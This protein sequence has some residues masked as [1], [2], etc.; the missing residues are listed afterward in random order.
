MILLAIHVAP[1]AR[2]APA[3]VS[4]SSA[5]GARFPAIAQIAGDQLT[6]ADDTLRRLRG[7]IDPYR[8]TPI[9]ASYRLANLIQQ[10]HTNHHA[11]A[12]ETAG[13]LLDDLR[14]LG[15]EAGY[16]HALMALSFY[17]MGEIETPDPAHRQ[18]AALWCSRA[19][20]LLS[21]EALSARFR[22]LGAMAV[23]LAPRGEAAP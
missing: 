3:S 15:A 2:A 18:Q 17:R 20:L 4:E 23:N 10:T 22:E 7:A 5:R 6:D 16:G 11:D 1:S 8:G 21:P 13:T 14:P 12:V 9:A 19:T